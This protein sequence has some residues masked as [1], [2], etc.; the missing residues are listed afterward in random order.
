[1]K[2]NRI[3][4]LV[5]CL[6]L[7][8]ACTP[9]TPRVNN[10]LSGEQETGEQISEPDNM[11]MEIE[12][13]GWNEELGV[14]VLRGRLTTTKGAQ[15]MLEGVILDSDYFGENWRKEVESLKGKRVEAKGKV[16]RHHCGSME[17][18]LTQ[19]YIDSLYDIEYVKEQ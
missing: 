3:V 7:G 13:E 16:L 12:T 1:M 5:L 14:K 2:L 6:S 18:C 17:Q 11:P 15:A 8:M 19:G 4:F 9:K 10:G